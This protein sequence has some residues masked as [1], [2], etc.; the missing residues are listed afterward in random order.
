MYTIRKSL[1]QL[2]HCAAVQFV[3]PLIQTPLGSQAWVKN[4]NSDNLL[5]V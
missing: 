1:K 4:N 3:Y 2:A 5:G